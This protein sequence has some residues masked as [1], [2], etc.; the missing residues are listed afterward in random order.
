MVAVRTSA[1]MKLR[2]SSVVKD[3][4]LVPIWRRTLSL[5]GARNVGAGGGNIGKP[6]VASAPPSM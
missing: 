4:G 5:V 6:L 3:D 1:S 2:S